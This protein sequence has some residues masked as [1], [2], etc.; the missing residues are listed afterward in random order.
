MIRL[1]HALVALLVLLTSC[2][3]S[4]QKASKA[5]DKKTDAPQGFALVEWFTS[6][7]CSSCPPADR[8]LAE[9]TQQYAGRPVLLVGMHVDYWDRLG[10]KDPFSEHIF[11]QRQRDY[12]RFLKNDNIYTP[13]AVVNG[14]FETNGANR[15]EIVRTIEEGLSA[16]P[17]THIALNAKAFADSIQLQYEAQGL[18]AGDRVVLLLVQHKAVT[19][20]KRGENRGKT[21]E[22]VN[23]VRGIAYRAG[24][25]ERAMFALPDGLTD[26]DIFLA[27]YVQD[28]TD[29]RIL[30]LALGELQ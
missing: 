21:L 28:G 25:L 11:S 5:V 12:S 30:G 13:Q 20:V 1:I 9:L 29:G 2:S 27:A 18:K 10:W 22:H 19:H 17:E 6:E 24:A 15:K 3:F 23:V 14:R 7:G 26:K 4:P 8:L 16:L